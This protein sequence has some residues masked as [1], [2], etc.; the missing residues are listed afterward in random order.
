M[1]ESTHRCTHFYQIWHV[2]GVSPLRGIWTLKASISKQNLQTASRARE[3]IFAR[4]R[5]VLAH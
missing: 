1:Y 3:D 2:D 5:L 4:E